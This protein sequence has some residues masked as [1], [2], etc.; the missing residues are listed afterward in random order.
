MALKFTPQQVALEL[1]KADLD[2]MRPLTSDE[3]TKGEQGRVA[4][5]LPDKLSRSPNIIATIKR[6]DFI[7]WWAITEVLKQPTAEKRAQVIE[8]LTNVN[9][10]LLKLLSYN[11]FAGI[12]HAFGHGSV[13]RL[14]KTWAVRHVFNRHASE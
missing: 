7:S 5:M 12:T 13:D 11:S 1:T 2:T 9:E 6:T 3:F 4:W 8:F 14:E 10:E